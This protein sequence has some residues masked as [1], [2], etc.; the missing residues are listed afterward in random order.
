M[1]PT[2]R[3]TAILATAMFLGAPQPAYADGSHTCFW[4]DLGA[5]DES[6]YEI[7]ANAC[8]GTGY[9]DVTVTVYGGEAKGTHRC[10]IA[11][12]WNG[13]LAAQGCAPSSP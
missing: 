4:G 11:F 1:R 5:Q 8:D 9:A 10:R 3:F 2:T 12:P 13:T 7:T 6:G